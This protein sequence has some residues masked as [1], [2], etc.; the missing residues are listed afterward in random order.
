MT[1]LAGFII[2]GLGVGASL[3][4][5][6]PQGLKTKF[7]AGQSLYALGE[8]E[9]AIVEYKRNVGF[10]NWAVR[11]D[12]VTVS[13]GDELELPVVE[14]AYYQLGNAYKRSGDHEKAI[15][16]FS[17]VVT[18]ENVPE[19]F[20]SLVQF[21][22]SETR[23][24]QREYG[25]AATEYLR[26]V[27]LFPKSEFAGQAYF[28]AGWSQFHEK[29]Y[30][31]AIG[32]LEGML[33]SYPEDRYAPD[34]KFR[35]ASSHFEKG[36]YEKTI[37]EADAV[38]ERFPTSPVV[39][40]A[41]YLKAQAYDK[42]G[43]SQLA[44]DSYREV[45][46][47]YDRMY[48]MLRGSFREGK[49]VDFENYRELF[50]TSSLRVAE[51]YRKDGQFEEAYGELIAAQET[52]DERFYKAKVQMRLGDNYMEWKRFDDAWRAYDQVINLYGDTPYP[53]NAQYQKGEARYFGGQYA[54]A[55]ADYI[56]VVENYPDSETSLR[57]A[58]L[59]SAGWS[60]EKLG[61]ADQAL[62][63][64]S[65][66]AENFSRS[67]Q[68]PL[69]LLRIGRVNTEQQRYEAA[70][71]AYQT[72][73]AN[74]SGTS[75]AAD[76]NYGLGI[77]YKQ[78]GRMD[79]A[80]AAFSQVGR[81]AREI[82]V[83][84]LIEAANIH[85]TEGRNER[86]KQLLAAL[87]EGVQGDRDLEATAHYQMAQLDLNLKNY[88]DAISGYSKVIDE[89][90]ESNVIRDAHYGRGL[91]YHYGNN[92]ARAL[93]DYGWL[94][95][96]DLPQA[97][98]LKVEFSMALSYAA[99]GDDANATVL[100]NK[101]IESGDE[102]LARNAQLQM[103]A[104]AEKQDP[105]DAIATYESMLAKLDSQEDRA[106]VLIRLASAYFRLEQYDRSIDASQRLIDLAIDVESIS[107]ALFVQANSFF[108]SGRNDDAI[109]TYQ[110]IIDNY[111]QIG[112][113]KNAQFQIALTYNRMSGGGHV[114]YLPK[115]Q[116]AFR[117]YH[118]TYPEDK[119]AVSA[120]YYDAWALY[121][122]GNWREAADTFSALAG[123]HARS[124]HAPEA[125]FRSGEAIFNLAQGLTMD[126]KLPI[127]EEAMGQYE[128]V[129]R[130]YPRS[131]YADDAL[132]NRA[133]ALINLGRKETA[134]PIFEQIVA[135]YPDGRYGGRSLYT[136]GDYYYGE[137]AYDKATENY[138]RFLEM[139]PEE[140]LIKEDKP[141][142]RKANVLLG[143]LSEIDAY[144]IYAEGEKLFD[145]E[146]YDG[147][148]EIFKQ[149]Q[150]KYPQSDQS[151]NA[152]VNIGSAYMASEDYRQAAAE[153]QRV[154]DKYSD[155]KRF[156]PQVDF[157]ESQLGMLREAGV[158]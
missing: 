13:F 115:M 38:L 101:V 116:Q 4:L 144:N 157:A 136:L 104:M 59:Y 5:P 114:E 22:V 102:T 128:A 14:A 65:Q 2:L 139:F 36:Q 9:G 27:E 142:R 69:C 20:R 150:T 21:Q 127:F 1:V 47:L 51:I 43:N 110:R 112:W 118:E 141:L 53:A 140:R 81:D 24:L 48:E 67:D 90:P 103:I 16:N 30:D 60:S 121:R 41:V 49:N 56:A 50:E 52:A 39:A 17:K 8:Y 84:S 126:Q 75:H 44:I 45:R 82:Y 137:K 70:V 93:K 108:R 87:L 15:E 83:A 125:L 158:I 119:N 62:E 129:L 25:K 57:A 79:D 68:A 64:Y 74:Y 97:M 124:Q 91:S 100:L 80:V 132:Y 23:F 88:R 55:S 154:V 85:I 61:D 10:S 3:F 73:A 152:A 6:V 86:G 35:I 34:S 155:V 134:V 71:E 106:R 18:A 89:Y 28:Y 107:N 111:P 94:L 29:R 135:D 147:A 11:N 117:T 122:L 151:V 149:V 96:S 153:F 133:W 26:Y 37:A 109:D 145:R 46:D 120:F 113:A 12:S 40:Q 146:D 77:L 105:Q 54:E 98:Q 31:E 138:E 19:E 63:L 66:V 72:V 33:A 143:H 7:D 148:I 76:A 58:S 123:K 99:L 95:D 130:R 32:T 156:S 78:Q 92:Y 42:M 131:E